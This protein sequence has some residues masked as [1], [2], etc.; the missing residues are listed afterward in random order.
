MKNNLKQIIRV[1]KLYYEEQITQDAIA[2]H[3]NLSRPTVSRI[4][5]EALDLG[6]VQIRVVD[7]DPGITELTKVL[8]ARYDMIDVVVSSS[9]NDLYETA[10]EYIDR[11]ICTNCSIGVSWGRTLSEVVNQISPRSEKNGVQVVQLLGASGKSEDP[12]KANEI[13]YR[14][15]LTYN[16]SYRLLPAPLMVSNK[17]IRNLLIE[18]SAISEVLEL[19]RKVDIALLGIGTSNPS[20]SRVAREKYVSMKEL[21]KLYETGAS[22]EI[23]CRFYRLDGSIYKHSN[24]DGIIGITLEDLKKIPIRIGVAFGE[25]K[26]DSIRGAMNGKYINVLITDSA[27]ARAIQDLDERLDAEIPED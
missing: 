18:E 6:I 4:L 12:A 19:S 23:C 8:K 22:G 17:K 2:K 16:G 13:A 10:A 20:V 7:L 26:V 21:E 24:D 27:T 5:K 1:A 15:A 25:K 11:K 3:E 9:L 14:L